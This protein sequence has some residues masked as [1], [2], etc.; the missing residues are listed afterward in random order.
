MAIIEASPINNNNSVGSQ[1]ALILLRA[2]FSAPRVQYLMRYS[3][4]DNNHALQKFDNLLRVALT[5][6]TNSSL[7][8]TQWL[9]ALSLIHI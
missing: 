3:P 7:S 5:N 9:Q 6:I 8:D 1:D 2:S 4:S